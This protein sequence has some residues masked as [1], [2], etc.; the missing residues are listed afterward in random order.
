MGPAWVLSAPDGPHVVLMN[1]AIRVNLTVL[2]PP[3]WVFN[4]INLCPIFSFVSSFTFWRFILVSRLL[5][6]FITEYS[7]NGI[8]SLRLVW[9]RMFPKSLEVMCEMQWIAYGAVGLQLKTPIISDKH[10]VS[11]LCFLM[12][13]IKCVWDTCLRHKPEIL[14]SKNF[15]SFIFNVFLY[16]EIAHPYHNLIDS[17]VKPRELES[18]G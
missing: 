7:P 3:L 8:V 1:L 5:I 15:Y 6:T 13:W 11:L 4:S 18:D 14:N 16:D 2:Y 17:L 12:V 10:N 9:G